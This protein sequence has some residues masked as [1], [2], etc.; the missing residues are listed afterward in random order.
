MKNDVSDEA[1]D[2]L[3]RTMDF[4]KDGSIDFNEF[5]EAFHVVHK[6]RIGTI[7]NEVGF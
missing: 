1:I 6:F 2:I 4:N 3:V 7:S 5:L